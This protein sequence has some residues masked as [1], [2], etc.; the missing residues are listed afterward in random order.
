MHQFFQSTLLTFTL[1]NKQRKNPEKKQ[2]TI[3]KPCQKHPRKGIQILFEND[4]HA[5]YCGF[6]WTRN[7][8]RGEC[9]KS[10]RKNERPHNVNSCGKCSSTEGGIVTV[11]TCFYYVFEFTEFPRTGMCTTQ[12]SRTMSIRHIMSSIFITGRNAQGE[13]RALRCLLCAAR[14]HTVQNKERANQF[15][16]S[17]KTIKCPAI[18]STK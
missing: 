14:Q 5:N 3:W 18:V 9:F 4:C 11:I 17:L 2:K 6:I 13:I 16:H 15:F 7:S 12:N 1:L 10:L 8:C